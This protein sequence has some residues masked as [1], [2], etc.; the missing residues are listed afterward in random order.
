MKILAIGA[1]GFIGLR[2]VRQLLKQWQLTQTS[3]AVIW[4]MLNRSR[5][6]RNCGERSRGNIQISPTQPTPNN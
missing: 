5:M 2:V 3:F 6:K 4:D 1:T